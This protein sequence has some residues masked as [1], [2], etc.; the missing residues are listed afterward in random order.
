[1]TTITIFARHADSSV[2]STEVE[3]TL[4]AE[5]DAA[6]E[7]AGAA[8]RRGLAFFVDTSDATRL[9]W[10]VSQPDSEGLVDRSDVPVDV[11]AAG[12]AWLA[13]WA[14]RDCAREWHKQEPGTIE[15][16]TTLADWR[17]REASGLPADGDRDFLVACY[18]QVAGR[19]PTKAE[20]KA[21]ADALCEH[22]FDLTPC[23]AADD[24]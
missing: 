13:V 7:A 10:G 5:I 4:R 22:L 11:R 2:L 14:G 18:D 16:G 20:S 23:A 9:R 15:R 17:M 8:D 1:M 3:R 12:E 24:D 19:E 6:L 21:F